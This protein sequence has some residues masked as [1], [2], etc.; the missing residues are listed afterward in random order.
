VV[1]ASQGLLPHRFSLG[2]IPPTDGLPI[3]STGSL[4][5][6]RNVMYVAVTRAK[7][8]CHISGIQNWATIKDPLEP[9]IFVQEMGLL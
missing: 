5:D 9:S 1:G 6:E 3:T 8:V 2:E 4:S 7:D